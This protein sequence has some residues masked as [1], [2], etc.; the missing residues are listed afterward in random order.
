MVAQDEQCPPLFLDIICVRGEG[1]ST[2]PEGHWVLSPPT[3][4]LA[5]YQVQGTTGAAASWSF[6]SPGRKTPFPPRGVLSECLA[7]SPTPGCLLQR[8][9]KGRDLGMLEGGRNMPAEEAMRGLLVAFHGNLLILVNSLCSVRLLS[10][11]GG[12]PCAV[13]R[14]EAAWARLPEV[15]LEETGCEVRS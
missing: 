10:R 5:G 3:A 11:K 13:C 9:D 14:G 7:D 8:R 6:D 2:R 1:G 15:R 12:V 4:C